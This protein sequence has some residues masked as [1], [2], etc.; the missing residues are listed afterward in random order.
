MLTQEVVA[1]LQRHLRAAPRQLCCGDVFSVALRPCTSEDGILRSL[2]GVSAPGKLPS[3]PDP[4]S[5]CHA[6][7]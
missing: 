2:H 6:L 5:G 3:A 7:H 1:A 4:T